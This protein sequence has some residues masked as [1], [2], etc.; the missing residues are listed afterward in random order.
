MLQIVTG[1]ALFVLIAAGS[2]RS[3]VY[4]SVPMNDSKA[5]M[6][7]GFCFSVVLTYLCVGFV[8]ALLAWNWLLGSLFFAPVWA[9]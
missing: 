8:L 4:T 7:V 2:Y 1:I 9:N 3:T 6:I 5:R